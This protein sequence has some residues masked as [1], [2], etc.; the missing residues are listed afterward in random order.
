MK[1]Y[2]R[3]T[4]IA[5][6]FIVSF[7]AGV[8]VLLYV[9]LLPYFRQIGL[10]ATVSLYVFLACA[11]VIAISFTYNFVLTRAANRRRAQR[12]ADLVTHEQYA[13]YIPGGDIS[14]MIH[15]SALHEQARV[16]PALP[17]PDDEDEQEDKEP[18][19]DLTVLSLW[20]KGISLRKIAAQ[21]NRSYSDVQKITS[22]WKEKHFAQKSK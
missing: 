5:C 13:I 19:D 3:L 20:E 7:V 15:V 10:G 8:F 12:H 4:F 16:V 14:R 17:A 1:A 11:C 21:T 9:S 2:N 6:V 22:E 18:A